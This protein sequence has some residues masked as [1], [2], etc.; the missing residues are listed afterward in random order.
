MSRRWHVWL[1]AC[2]DEHARHVV[3]V[4]TASSCLFRFTDTPESSHWLVEQ[5]LRQLHEQGG[6]LHYT[7]L[8]PVNLTTSIVPLFG[9]AD[10][11]RVVARCDADMQRQFIAATDVGRIAARVLLRGA[12]DFEQTLSLSADRLSTRQEAAV[13]CELSVEQCSATRNTGTCTPGGRAGDVAS[14]VSGG[15]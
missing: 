6:I 12:P 14:W 4:S 13:R 11:L 2:H 7:V 15:G 10:P 8:R 5:Q 1:R 9:K 3:Y